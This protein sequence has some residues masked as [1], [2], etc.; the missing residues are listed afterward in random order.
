MICLNAEDSAH[1]QGLVRALERVGLIC[2]ELSVAQSVDAEAKFERAIAESRYVVLGLSQAWASALISDRQWQ[3][4]D[5]AAMDKP[6]DRPFLV[7]ARLEPCEVPPA[8]AHLQHVDLFDPKAVDRLAAHLEQDSLLFT[9]LRDSQTYPTV[10]IGAQTWLARNLDYDLDAQSGSWPGLSAASGTPWGRLYTWEAA[11][12]ACPDGWHLPTDAEWRDLAT[13]CG[14]YRDMDQGYPREGV[15]VGR[16][17]QGFDVLLRGGSIGFEA[18]LAGVRNADGVFEGRGRTGAYWS[19]STYDYTTLLNY[20]SVLVRSAWVYVF[21]T[22]GGR[23]QL[24]RDHEL[25]IAGSGSPL[26]RD[27]GLSVRCVRD[28]EDARK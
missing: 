25:P 14:G 21:Y 13:Q 19:N 6:I 12:V 26:S 16:P 5:S 4:L 3:A 24:R 18:Q 11:R 28:F 20:G 27:W 22:L 10:K 17:E 23:V 2:T 8:L 15:S 1:T 9:D 7:P